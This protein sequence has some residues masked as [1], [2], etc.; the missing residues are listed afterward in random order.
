MAPQ[1]IPPQASGIVETRVPARL[2][3]LP[4]SGWHWM[5][6]VALGVTWI[7]DGL[8]VTLAGALAAT[9]KN[10]AALGLTDAQ[11]GATATAY[12]AGAVIGALF[13]GYMTDRHGRKKLFFITLGVYLAG[14]A[15]SGL[16]WNFWSFALFRA[17]TGAGI[18]GEY[19]AIN[20]AIDE[21][22][23]AR[24]RGQ[25]DLAINATYWLGAAMGAVITLFLLD[26]RNLPAWLGWRLVFGVGA[27]LGLAIL[28]F[29]HWVPES[30]RW[31][32]V[33]GQPEEAERVVAD[34]EE[35]VCAHAGPLPQPDGAVTRIQVRP[36]GT[37]WPEIWN[38]IA[39]V[40]RR[41]SI[42]GFVLMASQAFF[43]NAILFSY[44]LVLTRFY[45]VPAGG[46][47]TYMLPMALGNAIGPILMGRL[48]DVI[49]RK[50]MIVITYAAS[51][52]LLALTGWLFQIQALTAHTQ[53]LLW[54]VTFFIASAAASSAYLTVSEIFPLEIR[55]LAISIFYATGTLAGGV[56]APSLFGYLIGAGSRGY[57]TGGY[58]AAAVL[59]GIAA[60]V[61]AFL[62]V[63]A[64]RQ[65]LESIATPLSAA[66]SAGNIQTHR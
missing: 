42:L 56:G 43:Y 31:L 62:G 12:L 64:E 1:N 7:L 38:A 59:M 33:H 4:W 30:P 11:V 47:S 58:I 54:S 2:D 53:T 39:H 22:I 48:F 57:L 65:S 32:M 6:V 8:E 21:M 45:H 51:G 29:R 18:G 49:G 52:A 55:G 26:P 46:V 13:F 44:A 17:M 66:A 16:A 24:I 61:E 50:P 25:V 35:K 19:A 9:L 15:L 34:I 37:R 60:M 10:P 23:P 36:G 41:R 63:K 3:R 28:I 20:S 5:I 40:H 27:L 14:T